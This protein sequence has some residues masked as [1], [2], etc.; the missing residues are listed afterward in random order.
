MHYTFWNSLTIKMCCL[1]EVD[2]IL[3]EDWS[4]WSNCKAGKFIS[5]WYSSTSCHCGNT[6]LLAK[7][8]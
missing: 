8:V 2:M 6:I 4:S 1:I 7:N 5:N 3:E